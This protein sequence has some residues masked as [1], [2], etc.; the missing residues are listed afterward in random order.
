[1]SGV[2]DLITLSP[3]WDVFSKS[4]PSRLKE[5]CGRGGRKSYSQREWRTSR[6]QGLLHTVGLGYITTHKYK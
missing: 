6:N 3:N 1:M 5:L 2:R 4:L